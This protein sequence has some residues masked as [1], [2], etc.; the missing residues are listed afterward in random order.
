MVLHGK[1][2]ILIMNGQA[3]AAAKS[4][5][6]KVKAGK[7]PVSSA[8]DGQWEHCMADRKSWAASCSHL[9]TQIAD[10]A[11][12]VG[13]IVTMSFN[14]KSDNEVAA[15]VANPTLTTGNVPT[16]GSLVFDTTRKE[17]LWMHKPAPNTTLY[18]ETFSWK[19]PL[20]VGAYYYNVALQKTYKWDGTT[21]NE[22]QR[23]SGNAL[24]DS[25]DGTFTLGNLAQGNF[26]F[27][28]T[29]PLAPPTT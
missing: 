12:M 19:P 14:I 15:F 18:F 3:I 9:V 5:T 27:S 21:M 26:A 2:V 28:G 22:V 10:S 7:I 8:T 25:W 13:Q 23:L 24:V 16:S 29:G 17:F 11:S 20:I 4:C 1:D 6:I